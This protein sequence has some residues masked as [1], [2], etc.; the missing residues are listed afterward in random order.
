MPE[1]IG[2]AA[3]A[4]NGIIGAGNDIPWRLPADWQRFKSLTM[5]QVLIMGRKTYDSIGRAVA[6]SDDLRD[7]QGSNVARRRRTRGAFSG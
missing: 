6:G 1:I 5:G 3:V 7:H 2:I 4:A